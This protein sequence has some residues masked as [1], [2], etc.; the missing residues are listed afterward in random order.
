MATYRCCTCTR[1]V[2]PPEPAKCESCGGMGFA[3]IPGPTDAAPP[4]GGY[5][6]A[7]TDREACVLPKDHEGRHSFEQEAERPTA[8]ATANPRHR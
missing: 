1:E 3:L 8:T 5:C 7:G 6:G 2:A 4:P